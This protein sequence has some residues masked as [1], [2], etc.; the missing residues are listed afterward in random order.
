MS[1]T[2]TLDAFIFRNIGAQATPVASAGAMA[3]RPSAVHRR[4]LEVTREGFIDLT[5]VRGVID[6]MV[7]LR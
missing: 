1:C 7:R 5:T 2:W 3:R 4:R 6:A